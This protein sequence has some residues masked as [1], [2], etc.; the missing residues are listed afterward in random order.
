MPLLVVKEDLGLTAAAIAGVVALRARGEGDAAG[1][2]RAL[3][4]AVCAAL[5]CALTI[6]VLIPA[7]NSGGG[8]DYWTK[9]GD[10]PGPLATAFT[11]VDQKLRTVLWVLVPTTGLLALRSPLLLVLLPTLAWRFVSDDPHYWGT[12]WH[13]SAVLMPVTAL[14]LADAAARTRAGAG[15]PWLRA[16][17]ERLPLGVLAAALALST[18]LP[19]AGLTHTAAYRAGPTAEAGSRV[20]SVIPDG[21]EVAANVKP[22]AHL[23]G[24]CRVFWI[25]S[26]D[27][28]APEY[29]AYWDPYETAESMVVDAH[30]MH[31]DGVYR[32][33]AQE[34]GFWVLRKR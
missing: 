27:G 18:T 9:V 17:A 7:F 6:G 10:G 15:R 30:R 28:P 20:L 22:I 4:V 2:R 31:P 5:A 8:Y 33:V 12:D 21:A 32:V 13:Y 11:D 34:A 16:Y 29:I 23:T 24:R 26:A 19:V 14:A 3:T 1:V 25:G